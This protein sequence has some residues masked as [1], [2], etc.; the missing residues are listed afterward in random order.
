MGITA[1]LGLLTGVFGLLIALIALLRMLNVLRTRR[2]PDSFASASEQ[3]RRVVVALLP[4]GLGLF[5]LGAA[6]TAWDRTPT[7]LLLVVAI[8]L[9]AGALFLFA[10]ALRLKP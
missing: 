2:W 5:G 3:K 9:F 8:L 4:T 6:E 7:G 10:G 1:T